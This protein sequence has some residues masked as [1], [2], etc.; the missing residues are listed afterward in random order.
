M[1]MPR[2]ASVGCF[3]VCAAILLRPDVIR[4]CSAC[5]GQSDA[6]MAQG[7]NWGIIS[8]LAI[9]G[10]VLAGVAG[11]FVFLARRAVAAQSLEVAGNITESTSRA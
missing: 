6:P 3:I 1:R 2:L 7:M 11:F 8:L 4:A 9:I 5:F 10:M